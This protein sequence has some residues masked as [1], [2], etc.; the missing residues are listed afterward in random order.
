MTFWVF[1]SSGPEV[2]EA[3]ISEDGTL[4]DKVLKRDVP[5]DAATDEVAAVELETAIDE[6]GGDKRVPVGEDV[7]KG[8][9]DEIPG[10]S[11]RAEVSSAGGGCPSVEIPTP[12][13]PGIGGAVVGA[14]DGG[15]PSGVYLAS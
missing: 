13:S 14:P 7:A 2:G 8:G 3:D 9:A 12:H 11:N 5:Y 1:D 15:G 6:D 4:E 10:G